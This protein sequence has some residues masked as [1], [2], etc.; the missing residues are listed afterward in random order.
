MESRCTSKTL[1]GFGAF[2]C[3]YIPILFLVFNVYGVF[4]GLTSLLCFKG[5]QSH[6]G[7]FGLGFGFFE[8]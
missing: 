1:S 4:N 8:V 2:W 3:I 7:C 6:L 5:F